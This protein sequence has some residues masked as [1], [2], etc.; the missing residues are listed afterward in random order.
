[1]LRSDRG[2]IGFVHKLP[3]LEQAESCSKDSA[4]SLHHIPKIVQIYSGAV[5]VNTKQ[6]NKIAGAAHSN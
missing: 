6:A 4:C 2:E 1:M 5:K 3:F